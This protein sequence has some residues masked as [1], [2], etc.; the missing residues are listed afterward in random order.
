MLRN[1]AQVGRSS[2]HHLGGSPRSRRRRAASA[3]ARGSPAS[4]PTLLALLFRRPQLCR[5]D[6]ALPPSLESLLPR[7]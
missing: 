4:E 2:R 6:I 3:V 1:T 7:G 5:C